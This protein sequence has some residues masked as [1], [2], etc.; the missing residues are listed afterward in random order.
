MAS[1]AQVRKTTALSSNY[2]TLILSPIYLNKMLL[3]L[4]R[5]LWLDVKFLCK[6][7]NQLQADFSDELMWQKTFKLILFFVV[8]RLVFF[9][10]CKVS[11]GDSNGTP[12]GLRL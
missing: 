3:T 1:L 4:I 12:F 6:S 7:D 8:V 11:F 5:M 2:K 10:A 9:L